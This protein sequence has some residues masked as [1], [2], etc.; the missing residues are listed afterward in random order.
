MKKLLALF[1]LFG[2]V[3]C[4][5]DFKNVNHDENT[6]SLKC[7]NTIP[8]YHSYEEARVLLNTVN[9]TFDIFLSH[10]DEYSCYKVSRCRSTIKRGA[11]SEE[12]P[13]A[14]YR[15]DG[16][17]YETIEFFKGDLRKDYSGKLR[18]KLNRES[19]MLKIDKG[20]QQYIEKHW[21][22]YQCE[23]SDVATL[24]AEI[25]S[26]MAEVTKFKLEL[27]QKEQKEKQ[28]KDTEQSKKNVI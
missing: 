14:K 10:N 4:E 24:E 12:F 20:R 5:Q 19:L 1:L 8:D 26:Y 2:I 7:I 21:K 28:D 23:L 6:I 13:P 25:D 16:K 11:I 27:K 9:D 15:A 18:W 22:A 17:L 3:G